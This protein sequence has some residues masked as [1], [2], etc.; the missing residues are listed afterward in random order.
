MMQKI[1]AGE[2]PDLVVLTGD[3]VCSK[4]TVKAWGK[5]S[6]ILTDAKIFWAVTH[7]NLN[8]QHELTKPQIM[9]TIVGLPY[10]LTENGPKN[11]SG[12]GNY[13]LKIRSQK[14]NKTEAV[15]YFIDSQM[16][17]H[18]KTNIGSYEWIDFSQ[19]EWYRS[20]SNKF[21]GENNGSP[22]PALVFFHIPLPE[23]KEK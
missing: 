8:A 2:K 3:V 15:L 9:Q 10:N 7:G 16:G 6:E 23:Y 22:L 13:T 14:S 4:N 11:V 19:I 1:I 20:Q 5:L 12:N 18:P 21:T 17:F